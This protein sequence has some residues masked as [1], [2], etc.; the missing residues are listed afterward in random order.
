MDITKPVLREFHISRQARDFFGFD[1]S[2]FAFNGN[3]IFA[4][5][6]AARSFADKINQK[7]DLVNFPEQAVRAGQINALG[8]V[9]EILHVVIAQ[10]RQQLNPYFGEQALNWLYEKLGRDRVNL[11]LHRFSET[12]PPTAVYQGKT[13]LE[14]YLQAESEQEPRLPVQLEE[15]LMLWI[16]NVNPACSPYLELFDDGELEKETLYPQMLSELHNFFK[17]QPTFGPDNQDLIDMLR[18]PAIAEP[19]SLPGQ[20]EYIRTRWSTILGKDIYRLLSSLDLVKEEEKTVFTGP[21]PA[22][23]YEFKGMELEP[24]QFSP[25]RDWMPSLVLV[26][27]NAYVWLDQLSKKYQRTLNR[28]DQIPDEELDQLAR[29]G[30]TGL[31]LIGLW[32][33]SPASQKIKQMRGNPDAVASAY[34]LSSY[35]IASELGGE[36][37]YQKLRQRAWQRGIRLASDM[38]P[39]HMGIDSSWVM[40]HPEWFIGLEF[41]PYPS[42]RFSGQNLSWDERVGIYLEDHY[43]DN[44]DAAVVFKR[45]DFWT[46]QERYIYHGNDGTSMPWNDTAQLNYLNPAVREAVI[47]TIL[48]VARKFPVIRFD[49]AMTLAK[50][51][52]QRLWYPEPGTGGAIPSRAEHGMTKDR[53]DAEMPVEF[54][55]EVVDRVAQE[56]PDTLLLAEAFW[57]MEGYFVRTLGMHRVYNSAF[58]NMLRDEKNQ[59]YRLV[60]KNTLE[61]DPEILKRYVNFMNNP[62]ERTAIDQFGTGDKYFGICMLMATMPGLPM[63]GHGQIEG[64]TEKYGMEY[65]RAYWEELPNRDLVARHE[66]EIFPLLQRRYLFAEAKDFLLYDFYSPEGIVNEDVY[67]Y[68]NRAGNE[69]SLVVYHNRYARA[70]GWV[71]SSAAFLD[72]QGETSTSREPGERVLIQ[73]SLAEGLQLN[74]QVGY[75]TILRDNISGLEFIRDNRQLHQEGLYFELEAYKYQVFMDIREVREDEAHPYGQLTDF[76][77]GRGVPSIEAALAEIFLQP[78]HA[79]FRNLVNAGQLSWLIENRIV[80][81]GEDH[82]EPVLDEVKTKLFALL[83]SVARFSGNN[84]G[85]ENIVNESSQELA[86]LLRIMAT[87]K[88][89]SSAVVLD[90]DTISSYLYGDDDTPTGLSGGEIK[91]WGTLLGWL[92]THK[93]GKVSAQQPFSELSR[94]WI[95]QWRLSKILENTFQ[96]LGLDQPER[97]IAITRIKIL[98]SHADWLNTQLPGEVNTYQILEGWLRDSEIQQLL[99]IN[100]HQGILWFNKEAFE[101]LLWWMTTIAVI[102]IIPKFPGDEQAEKQLVKCFQI[103]QELI[104]AEESSGYQVEKLLTAVRDS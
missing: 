68:S 91:I 80:E 97:Q 61:F 18:S 37:A 63:F 83:E 85:V 104:T 11:A 31:W 94:S 4:D 15:L 1:Q 14:D 86:A 76:L 60:I 40:E 67:A 3:V 16:A 69:R 84:L 45:V 78:I 81:D 19:Y 41:S 23:I 103:I 59:E 47:Q 62:D 53:F 87:K 26:A 48:S 27:K 5:F 93:I 34:S 24:E 33:R 12:F 55:R 72:K 51:H 73:K 38:V 6:H 32:E 39:N 28:L 99:E 92:F 88:I 17:T 25:D 52:Y 54:W 65:R 70:R 71:R 57:L 100:R 8:L 96:D 102:Q 89:F 20:L 82:T 30:F 35:D 10:Y 64:F 58:M 75:Y 2:L 21:G 50:K 66:R 43:L 101:S 95:D 36:Q 79:P 56:V 90:D 9:D 22:Y 74:S 29:W 49:A 46:G 44:S 7:R 42:Y 98:T 13:S 77:N